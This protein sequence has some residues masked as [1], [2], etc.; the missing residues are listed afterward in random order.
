MKKIIFTFINNG[1]ANAQA[2][3]ASIDIAS[4]MSAVA[5]Q[6]TTTVKTSPT[7]DDYDKYSRKSPTDNLWKFSAAF[8]LILL[9]II[10]MLIMKRKKK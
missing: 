7:G 1:S 4:P 6:D 5:A 2:T 3:I 9:V 8:S 10:L